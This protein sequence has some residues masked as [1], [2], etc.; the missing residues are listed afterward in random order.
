MFLIKQL[1]T[2][3]KKSTHFLNIYKGFIIIFSIKNKYYRI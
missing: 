2:T 3:E 1:L